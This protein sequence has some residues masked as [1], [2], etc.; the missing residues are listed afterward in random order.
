MKRRCGRRPA[1]YG[2]AGMPRG[3]RMRMVLTRKAYRQ[4][5]CLEQK[6][7]KVTKSWADFDGL[8]VAEAV[9]LSC[10]ARSVNSGAAGSPEKV[11]SIR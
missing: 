6:R 5:E 7:T 2:S 8:I 4:T 9:R 3:N 10:I 1:T 11:S